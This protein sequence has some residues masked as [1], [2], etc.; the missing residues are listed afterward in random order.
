MTLVSKGDGG[1]TL[2]HSRTKQVTL[3]SILGDEGY[4]R[5]CS[6]TSNVALVSIG[7]GGYAIWLSVKY[8]VYFLFDR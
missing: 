3:V 2:T 6:R 5:T 7:H 8:Y 1:Y 4:A